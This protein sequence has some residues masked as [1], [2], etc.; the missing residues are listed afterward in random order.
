VENKSAFKSIAK[1]AMLLILMALPPAGLVWLFGRTMFFGV[2]GWTLS[3]RLFAEPWN[4]VHAGFCLDQPTIGKWY[5]WFTVLA[6]LI[7][8]YL[9]MVRRFWGK[10]ARTWAAR[11][12]FILPATVLCLFLVCLLTGPFFWLIQYIANMGWTPRRAFGLLYGIA[13]YAA[14][15]LFGCWAIGKRLDGTAPDKYDKPQKSV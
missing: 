2:F 7:L 12:I 5:F 3:G 15:L 14:V 4:R 1:T 9:A 11:W 13:G 10:S 8:P 6:A